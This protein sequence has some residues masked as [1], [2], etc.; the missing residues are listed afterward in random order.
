MSKPMDSSET[1]VCRQ[2]RKRFPALINDR[3]TPFNRRAAESLS[4]TER[5]AAERHLQT[6]ARCAGEYRL[7]KLERSA[8][9][10]SAAPDGLAPDPDF[11]V[12][13][14]ARIA[15]GPETAAERATSASDESWA[16]ALMLTARQFIPAMAMLLLLIIG[17]T[18]VWSSKAP[19]ENT[20][21]AVRPS[22]RIMFNNLYDYPE[23]TPD[24]V[25][26]SLVAVEDKENGK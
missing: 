10:L 4:V 19:P 21:V 12:A 16:A 7:M 14:R 15:R 24:D 2:A 5:A 22:D 23:P 20:Q 9:D 8:L 13:L 11:F 25:L 17:A 18:L 1:M 6:C 3:A 26:E